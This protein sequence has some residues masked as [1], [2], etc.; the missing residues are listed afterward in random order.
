MKLVSH[1]IVENESELRQLEQLEIDKYNPAML[2]NYK[3]AYGMEEDKLKQWDN[4][5]L[6]IEE[7]QIN[8]QISYK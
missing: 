1:H 3:K 4:I 2:L 6:M 8:E 5:I 7:N